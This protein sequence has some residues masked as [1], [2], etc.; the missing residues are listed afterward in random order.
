MRI[1]SLM[2]QH[3]Q[4]AVRKVA[5]KIFIFVYKICCTTTTEKEKEDHRKQHGTYW[6]VERSIDEYLTEDLTKKN[7][8]KGKI[9]ATIKEHESG[10]IK[11]VFH[12]AAEI[13][14]LFNPDLFNSFF[15][16]LISL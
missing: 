15:V 8:E 4:L 2:I 12:T 3:K 1:H 10:N 11:F 5:V 14:Y 13:N 16:I 7:N 6:G 9:T